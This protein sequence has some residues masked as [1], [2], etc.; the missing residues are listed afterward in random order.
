[1][2]E[3]VECDLCPH[4]CK[5]AEGR[6]G[7]C[8]ARTAKGG[9][10]ISLTFGE[11]ASVHLDPI[12]KKPLY[13]FFP[14]SWILSAGGYGCNLKCFYCQNHEISQKVEP[15]HKVSPEQL[16]RFSEEDESIGICFTY[17]EP[18]VWYEMI[19]RTAPLVKKQGGKVLLVS[20]GII[21]EKYLENLIPFLDAANIDIKG[22]T[23]EFY[24]KHTGGKLEWVLR[25][26]EKLAPKVHTEITTLV[27]PTLNDSPD[28]IKG[29]AS[30]LAKLDAPVAWH[31][32]R[33][34]PMY[35]CD[36]P[37]TEEKKLRELWGLAKDYLPYVYLGNMAGGNNTYCPQCG[38]EVIKRGREITMH[39]KDSKCQRCGKEIWGI[40]LQ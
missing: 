37:P 12:E 31:L 9:E 27:I 28:E 22:F 33:Y 3:V 40:G 36:I 1:M 39:T 30:W 26:V 21:E 4:H 18:L 11:V 35:Q 14:G 5:L 2:T 25:T 32:S 15:G 17:S 8:K 20:N 16:A 10:I 6:T 34:F 24:R 19:A 13:H 23:E 7:F 29:L 38:S